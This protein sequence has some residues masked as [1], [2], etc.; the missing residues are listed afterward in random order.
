[1]LS[2]VAGLV[3]AY[4]F[5]SSN[6]GPTNQSAALGGLDARFNLFLPPNAANAKVPVLFY[7]SGLTCTEDNGYVRLARSLKCHDLYAYDDSAHRR[8]IFLALLPKKGSLLSSLILPRAVQVSK[9]KTM[10]TIL[11]Q[12]RPHARCSDVTYAHNVYFTSTP[13][14]RCW[15]LPRRHQS[16]VCSPLQH[17]HAY[18][19]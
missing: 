6:V 1:M 17:A 4:S 10:I 14:H 16:K 15:L 12:V 9:A 7:L 8:E 13:F 11:A 2:L 3:L 5:R 18:P 19:A